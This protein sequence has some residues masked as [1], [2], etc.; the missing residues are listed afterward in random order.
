M[1]KKNAAIALG[2]ALLTGSTSAWAG[3]QQST[4]VVITP[5][6]NCFGGSLGSARN[7][8]DNLQYLHVSVQASVSG[9]YHASVY[10]RDASGASA[11]CTTTDL[12]LIEVLRSVTTDSFLMVYHNGAGACST[13]EVVQAS[14][15]EPKQ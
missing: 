11:S 7:S 9:L 6:N 1:S 14:S 8:A 15:S 2:L 12:K 4:P 3:F 13:I 5:A 10:V